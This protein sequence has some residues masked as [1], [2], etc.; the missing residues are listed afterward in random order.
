M[1]G[2]GL[3]WQM[4]LVSLVTLLVAGGLGIALVL[5]KIYLPLEA[6]ILIA[7]AMVIGGIVRQKGMSF[8]VSTALCVSLCCLMFLGK[9][10][11]PPEM[12]MRMSLTIVFIAG[13]RILL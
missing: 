3:I 9:I 4:G 13:L 7:M 5:M 8:L 10:Y 12:L 1:V 2:G 6:V 11:L